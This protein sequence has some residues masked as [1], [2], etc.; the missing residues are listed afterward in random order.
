GRIAYAQVRQFCGPDLQARPFDVGTPLRVIIQ[1]YWFFD[2]LRSSLLPNNS[3]AAFKNKAWSDSRMNN[4]AP[5]A[6]ISCISRSLPTIAPRGFPMALTCSN[7]RETAAM[8]DSAL[9]EFSPSA[10]AR[11]ARPMNTR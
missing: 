7:T 10:T 5:S 9:T 6:R 1:A 11:S 4:E 3:L 8:T 2:H